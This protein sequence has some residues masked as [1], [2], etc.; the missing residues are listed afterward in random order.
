MVHPAVCPGFRRIRD[1]WSKRECG[2]RCASRGPP[3]FPAT[4]PRTSTCWKRKARAPTAW[5]VLVGR[6]ESRPPARPL[7]LPSRG[8]HLGSTIRSPRM[9]GKL[10]FVLRSLSSFVPSRSS[11]LQWRRVAC[12][13]KPGSGVVGRPRRAATGPQ[14]VAWLRLSGC[15]SVGRSPATCNRGCFHGRAITSARS[16]A[17][18][19]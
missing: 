6:L 1:D 12:A 10:A 4:N 9:R 13:V 2:P 5:L 14:A 7:P 18:L 8:V 16:P 15:G 3:L 11:R 17:S 19:A